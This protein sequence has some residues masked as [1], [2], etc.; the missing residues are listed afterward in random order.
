[1]YGAVSPAPGSVPDGLG[2]GLDDGLDD[3][4]GAGLA[5]GLGEGFADGLGEGLGEG[6]AVGDGLGD[7]LAEG[8]GV[9][10]LVALPATAVHLSPVRPVRARASR[11]APAATHRQLLG[12]TVLVGAPSALW[13]V[14]ASVIVATTSVGPAGPLARPYAIGTNLTRTSRRARPG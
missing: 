13:T 8:V 14:S 6:V 9:P 1:M 12:R 7:G 10:E 3:G 2:A 5:E 11:A 4:L